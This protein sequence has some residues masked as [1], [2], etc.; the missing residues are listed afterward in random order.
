MQKKY[1]KNLPFF[2][3]HY[4]T[5]NIKLY[6]VRE[7]FREERIFNECNPCL[8]QEGEHVKDDC[9][10][11]LLRDQ[12]VPQVAPSSFLDLFREISLNYLQ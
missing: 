7:N 6:T 9:Y 11:H 2:K 1:T 10:L 4:T 5:K 12:N 8:A 3:R